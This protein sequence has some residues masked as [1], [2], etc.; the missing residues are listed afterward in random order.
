M[1]EPER[2]GGQH[3][4]NSTGEPASAE[5]ENFRAA[6]LAQ[7]ERRELRNHANSAFAL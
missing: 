1:S 4:L 6:G 5:L 3:A 7:A 2:A